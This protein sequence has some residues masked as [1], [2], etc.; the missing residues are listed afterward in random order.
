LLC[1]Q[2]P[3]SA[4][5]QEDLFSWVEH[6]NFTVFKRTVLEPLHKKRLIEY[7]KSADSITISPIGIKEV[8]ERILKPV[9]N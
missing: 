9:V 3:G 6:S 4:V 2:E 8:E 1:Y 5:L 7:D